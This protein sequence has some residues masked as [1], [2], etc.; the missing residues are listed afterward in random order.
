MLNKHLD[1]VIDSAR[2]LLFLEQVMERSLNLTM[3]KM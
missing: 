2:H 3:Y 1:D